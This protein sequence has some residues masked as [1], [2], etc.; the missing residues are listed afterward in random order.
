[1]I[2]GTTSG[3]DVDNA[4]LTRVFFLQLRVI[5]STMGTRSELA[6]LT[7]LLDVSGVRPLIDRVLPMEQARDGFAAM[8]AGDVFGKVVFTR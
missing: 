8:A 2:S 1:V 7:E 5:G 6:A 4:E 3:A